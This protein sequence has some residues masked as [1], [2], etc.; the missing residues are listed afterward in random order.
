MS[1][2]VGSDDV[3]LL[4]SAADK[5]NQN[6][7]SRCQSMMTNEEEYLINDDQGREIHSVLDESTCFKVEQSR[8]E[9]AILDNC[10][11]G[12]IRSR[13]LTMKGL[14]HK[15]KTLRERKRK[16]NSG[17]IRKYGT[18][19]DLL[20]SGTN[21]VAVE[22]E[23]NQFNDLL[24]IRTDVHQDCNQLL[25]DDEREKDDD[26][27]DK[28]NTQACS[29]KRKVHCWLRETAQKIN[30]AKST[31]RSSKSISD[32]ESGNSRI[33]KSSHRSRS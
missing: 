15:K 2:G 23:M 4:D 3:N 14:W 33:S 29:F 12:F 30:S 6:V 5:M 11:E 17:L 7:I 25:D 26:R 27:F 8:R 13:K 32:K 18:T 10:Q 20:C 16:I 28:I 21:K 24:K 1:L 22:E 9:T 19:E 31:S